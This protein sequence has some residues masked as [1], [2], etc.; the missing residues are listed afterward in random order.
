M[1]LQ[2]DE[3]LRSGLQDW[4]PCSRGHRTLIGIQSPRSEVDL[5]K[6]R[7]LIKE[8]TQLYSLTR[9]RFGFRWI[10]YTGDKRSTDASRRRATGI[11]A[12][13]AQQQRCTRSRAAERQHRSVCAFPVACSSSGMNRNDQAVAQ[14]A[15][16]KNLIEQV[17]SKEDQ[18]TKQ[19][20]RKRSLLAQL[21]ENEFVREELTLVERDPGARLY[22]LHGP[23]LL[24]KRRADVADNVKQ[25]QDLLLGEIRRVDG[26]ISNLE[27]ELQ[28]LQQRLREAQ[29]QL[30]TPATTTA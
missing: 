21:Q 15:A 10:R 13:S 20:A 11:A 24:P 19:V 8:I 17:R 28:E 30:T 3:L 5:L 4:K 25:R 26:V 18:W 2:A 1:T 9:G 14:V 22:K 27:R 12:S 7:F 29:R 16:L 6:T 23:C